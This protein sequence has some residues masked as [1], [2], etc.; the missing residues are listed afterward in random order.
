[1]ATGIAECFD[2]G[3]LVERDLVTE[4][5]E[6]FE[7]PDR[8][9]GCGVRLAD[10]QPGIDSHSQNDDVLCVDAVGEKVE[11]ANLAIRLFE[12]LVTVFPEVEHDGLAG[13]CRPVIGPAAEL[14]QV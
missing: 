6:P 3:S 11:I 12:R 9:D 14:L 4:V 13:P 10:R 5:H 1:E 8:T 7:L 2:G